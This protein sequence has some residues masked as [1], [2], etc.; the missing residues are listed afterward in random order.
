MVLNV[1]MDSNCNLFSTSIFNY[2]HQITSTSH[3][4]TKSNSNLGLKLYNSGS[5]TCVAAEKCHVKLSNIM[6]N[7]IGI[8]RDIELSGKIEEGLIQSVIFQNPMLST[9]GWEL[10]AEMSITCPPKLSSWWN[11]LFT[12]ATT[13]QQQQQQQN[14][15]ASK[16]QFNFGL[17]CS[18]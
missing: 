6:L 15:G 9:C 10:T 3:Y 17:P 12:F 1:S 14:Y 16:C 7:G 5:I 2:A 4:F 11:S 8:S 13:T 18:R